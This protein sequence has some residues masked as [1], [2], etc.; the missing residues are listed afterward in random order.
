[1]RPGWDIAQVQAAPFY[2]ALRP[3]LERFEWPPAWPTL[4]DYQ[5]LLEGAPQPL[6][7][8]SGKPL[9]VVEQ[10]QEKPTHWR[11]GYEPRIY[12][13]GELQTRLESWH[14]C[15]NLL[16]WM[17]FPL[18]KAALNARQYALLEARARD[19]APAG[20][21]SPGQDA[22]TQFD[23][24]GVVVLSVEPK[25]SEL[26]RN[27]QWK[28][29]F[30]EQRAAVKAGM[31]CLAFGHGL[32]E[33]ALTPYRGITGKGV[34]LPVT[35]QL[36]AQPLA[37]QLAEVDRRLAQYLNDT[38]QLLHPQDLAPVPLLGFPGFTPDN[39][40]AAYY[41]DQRYFRPGRMSKP[42]SASKPGDL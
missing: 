11:Q 33:R 31:R 38:Q 36:L 35:A 28:Q 37:L 16:T 15:F 20:P 3:A 10:A 12:L 23:E 25:L 19:A 42:A 29:L 7:T 34:I 41:D 9:R 5:R 32:M 18:A 30:W 40:C 4:A 14:D 6:L 8:A 24:S 17:S 2:A 26:L 27:F 22:L 39:E 1:M 21:R 13:Q